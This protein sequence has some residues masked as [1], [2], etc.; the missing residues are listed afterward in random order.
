MLI[1]WTFKIHEKNAGP[2]LLHGDAPVK[3]TL[4]EKEERVLFSSVTAR[5]VSEYF[6]NMKQKYIYCTT[7]LDA[8]P[9]FAGDQTVAE[10][11]G[12]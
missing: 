1:T 10:P 2:R 8:A 5:H 7:G 12:D 4:E 6:E 9:C 11:L 3:A